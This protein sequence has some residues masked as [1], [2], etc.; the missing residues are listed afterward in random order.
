[1]RLGTPTD[2]FSSH[3]KRPSGE[4]PRPAPSPKTAR[5][6]N[7]RTAALFVIAI[8]ISSFFAPLVTVDPPVAGLAHWSEF[9]IVRQMYNGNL[10]APTCERCGEPLIRSLVAIPFTITSIYVLM[11]VALW[12]LSVPYASKTVASIAAIGVMESL[13]IARVGTRWSFE[14]TFY[15]N[16]RVGHVHYGMLQFVLFPVMLVLFLVSI[17]ED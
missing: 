17:T 10:P 4:S 8:G 16:P 1:M 15:R 11:V 14:D 12:P 9:D 7:R 13:Y 3:R 5:D 6:G 2:Y